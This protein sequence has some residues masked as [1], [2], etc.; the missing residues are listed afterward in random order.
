VDAIALTADDVS[1]VNGD[2]CIGCGACTP[3]C[4]AEAVALVLREDLKLP[5]DVAEFLALRYK[6]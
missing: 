4:P 5:P 6:M 3:T 2:R 1:V